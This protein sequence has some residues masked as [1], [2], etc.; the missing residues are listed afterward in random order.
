[1]RLARPLGQNGLTLCAGQCDFQW[2]CG[3]QDRKLLACRVNLI[4]NDKGSLGDPAECGS[5][6]L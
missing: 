5:C 4:P 1:M 6:F 2:G 3:H